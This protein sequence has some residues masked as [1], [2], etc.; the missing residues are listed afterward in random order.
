[1]TLISQRVP[2]FILPAVS[3]D[4]IDPRS[5]GLSD[6]LGRWLLVIFYPRDFSFVC[7]TELTSF[8]GRAAD[9]ASAIVACWG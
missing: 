1:M 8:S 9:F 6:Y 7:P 2:E 3:I 4:E 5:I